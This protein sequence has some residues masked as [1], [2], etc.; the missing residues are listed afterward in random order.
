MAFARRHLNLTILPTGEV[1]ATG[2]V[3]GTTF[4]DLSRPVRAA[5]IWNPDTGNWRTLASSA[6]TRGYHATSI[7]LPDGRVLHAGSGDYPSAPRRLNAELFSPPYLFAGPRPTIGSAPA[8][9]G[10]NTTF[11]VVTPQAATIGKVSL[12]RLGSTTH[13]FDQN[14]RFVPLSFTA[15]A[16]GLT[17]RAPTQR[18]AAP[19]GHYMLFILNDAGVPSVAKIVRIA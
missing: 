10:Y 8:T 17:V 3:N 15:D 11:R 5:E 19:P 13:A 2:G 14:Q 18:T 7:L 9:V 12:I 1:L 6:V 4:N 16:T